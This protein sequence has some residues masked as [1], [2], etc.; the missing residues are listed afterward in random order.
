MHEQSRDDMAADSVAVSDPQAPYTVYKADMSYFS[1]KLEAYMRYKAIPHT[2]VDVDMSVANTEIYPTTGTR[3]VPA[4]R[5]ADGQWLFDTT[6][7]IAWFEERYSDGPVVP[8]DPALAFIAA[9]LE[10]YADEWL[11]RPSMWW[12]WEPPPS[13]RAAGWRIG[14][15]MNLGSLLTWAFGSYYAHRQRQEWLWNDGVTKENAAA[16]RDMY[17]DE[18]DFLQPLLDEQPY[19][20]GSHPSV[21]DFGYFGSMFRHFGNDPDPSEVMRRR[22][23]AVYEWLARLW[24]A[25]VEKLGPS[26]YWEWPRADYWQPLLRRIARAYFPYL[27]QNALAF[28]GGCARFDFRGER[29]HFKGTTTTNYRVWCREE[30]QRRHLSL[31]PADRARVDELFAPHGGLD[32]LHADGVIDSGMSEHYRLPRQPLTPR[33]RR[34][35]LKIAVFGQARN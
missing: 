22:A 32:V 24:N 3:K 4:V 13:R 26:Q 12:R 2:A 21:A 16:V 1:G 33:D 31:E 25:S 20:L 17:I 10:D 14:A 11:W 19:I 30:L 6:P 15:L 9:L 5:T 35:P 27:H 34:L 18:L 8:G 28:R 7:T 29:L 23:P